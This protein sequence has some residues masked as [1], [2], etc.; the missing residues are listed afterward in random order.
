M[1]KWKMLICSM[2]VV[3]VLAACG[4]KVDE[5]TSEVYTS[6]AEEIV[7]FLNKGEFEKITAQFDERMAAS[8]TATKLAEISPV[9][10]KSGAFEE[11][12]K[13]SV[14]EKD[15]LKIVVLVG[16]HSKDNRVYTVTYDANDKIA[17]LFVQ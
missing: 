1:K 15:G 9:L 13:K 6:K 3:A 7:Q 5:E 14:E 12:K 16:K 11:I 10:E 2:L 4:N 8:L 17:G